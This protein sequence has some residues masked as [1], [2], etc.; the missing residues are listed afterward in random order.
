MCVMQPGPSNS[1]S[2]ML[3]P[4][5]MIQPSW[6]RPLGSQLEARPLRASRTRVSPARYSPYGPLVMAAPSGDN[7]SLVLHGSTCPPLLYLG[8]CGKG[9]VGLALVPVGHRGDIVGA[10]L[11]G[12]PRPPAKRLHGDA[13]I[14]G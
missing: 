2:T 12:L 13:Q 7:S 14:L 4:A 9:G 6:L 1:A 3:S 10:R 8:E 5:G 11:V